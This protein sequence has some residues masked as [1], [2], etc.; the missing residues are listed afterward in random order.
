MNKT[1]LSY[2]AGLFDGEGCFHVRRNKKKNGSYSYRGEISITIR[3]KFILDDI[4]K[5]FGGSVKEHSR[6]E[7]DGNNG[8]CWRWTLYGEEAF[9]FACTLAPYL[10][11]K[12]RQC[13]TMCNI[14]RYLYQSENEN[15]ENQCSKYYL[16]LK[17][18]NQRGPK[19]GNA[20]ST[21]RWLVNTSK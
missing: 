11:V 14:G 15:I 3:E 2:I 16:R 13:T 18:Y 9:N 20:K 5:L 8:T 4:Q 10:Q 12:S 6:I 7:R 1:K 17:K 19:R 21:N